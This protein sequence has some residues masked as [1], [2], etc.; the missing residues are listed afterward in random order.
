[1][2]KARREFIAERDKLAFVAAFQGDAC[3]PEWISGSAG[4]VPIS[5]RK[6]LRKTAVSS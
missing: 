4:D 5:R 3:L 1:M 2:G 6:S